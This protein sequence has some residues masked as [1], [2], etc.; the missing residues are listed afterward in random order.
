MTSPLGFAYGT[1]T[2]RA[3]TGVESHTDVR[4]FKFASEP[5]RQRKSFYDLTDAEVKVLCRAV[6]H[7]RNGT[8]DDTRTPPVDVPLSVDSP[9]QWDQWVMTHARHCTET[10]PSIPQVH[11]SWFFL[12]WH[13]AYLYFLE[14]LLANFVTTVL[15]EDGSKFALPYW[16]WITR[17]DIPNTLEREQKGQPSPL[18]G[19][20]LSLE[21]MNEADVLGFDNLALWDG[22]R[23]PSLK[24]PKMD[25]ANEKS[26]KSKEEIAATIGFMSKD[27]IE[28]LLKMPWDLFMGKPTV[29]RSN[30]MGLLE[31]NP[32]N[33]GHDW[34]GSRQGKN[35]DMG[36][37]RYAALD[38]IFFMHHAN[39]DRIWSW[40]RK[41]QPDP[42]SDPTYGDERYTFIDVDGL[43]VTVTVRDI[44]KSITNISYLEP[45]SP[46][47][48][49]GAMLSAVQA[50]SRESL[51]EK[52]ETLVREPGTLTVKPLTLAVQ[53][54][55]EIMRL[56]S[57]GT[58][59]RGNPLSVLEIQTGSISYV[60]RFSINV[61]VNKPDANRETSMTDVHFVGLI[62][63][64]DAESRRAEADGDFTHTF[65]VMLGRSDANFYKLVGSGE[66]FTI[67]LVAQ[68]PNPN[69]K[70]FHIP[71]KSIKLRVF[72]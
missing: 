23:T 72:E 57:M 17:K 54:K 52:S 19:Y 18:F 38:P 1:A 49:I 29:S 9:L 20:D 36:T 33:N 35:R 10:G 43:P 32:H 71:V 2:G 21:T 4:P 6:G 3:M 70:G 46:G 44:I 42:D 34:V 11:W 26:P 40:Y 48:E 47:P 58:S 28:E 39:I 37:L 30:G 31:Q 68:G 24:N 14:R 65:A 12:P 8:K 5:R 15:H 66:S 50:V 63:A 67:T 25:S 27:Y 45:E 16:D 22:Y 69:D 64:L 55:P 51:Q 56:F 53:R 61:F 60:G 41:P 7:M 13:R 59:E 62:R